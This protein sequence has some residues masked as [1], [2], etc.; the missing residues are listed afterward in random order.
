MIKKSVTV[1]LKGED[2]NSVQIKGE[3]LRIDRKKQLMIVKDTDT[4][5]IAKI[6]P[7]P[8]GKDITEPI[9]KRSEFTYIPLEHV[10]YW[11]KIEDNMKD[12]TEV[13]D[14]S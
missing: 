3:S 1:I 11:Q 2:K 10:L 9:G 8:S 4:L 5:S 14:E 7:N 12:K 6:N 13:K